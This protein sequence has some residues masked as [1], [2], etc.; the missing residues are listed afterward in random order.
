MNWEHVEHTSWR[1]RYN[2]GLRAIR[3]RRLVEAV[4]L[5]GF[6]QTVPPH[7]PSQQNT[8]EGHR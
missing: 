2:T 7:G 8:C 3:P 5:D 4:E 1:M 6:A